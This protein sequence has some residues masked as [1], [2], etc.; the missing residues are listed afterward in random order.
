MI[1]VACTQLIVSVIVIEI[2][3]Y[4]SGAAP[5]DSVMTNRFTSV[6]LRVIAQ[7]VLI[8]V[9]TEPVIMCIV[10]D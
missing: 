3:K 10:N 2:A 5:K 6:T 4:M 7:L 8:A 9:M 1:F